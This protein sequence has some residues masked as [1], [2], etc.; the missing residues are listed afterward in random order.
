MKIYDESKFLSKIYQLNDNSKIN[1]LLNKYYK[2]DSG[3][4]VVWIVKNENFKPLNKTSKSIN[5]EKRL[6]MLGVIKSYKNSFI[7]KKMEDGS[8]R[9]VTFSKDFLFKSFGHIAKMIETINSYDPRFLFVWNYNKEIRVKID[10][11]GK[12]KFEFSNFDDFKEKTNEKNDIS[13]LEFWE[14]FISLFPIK[15]NS[16]K[17]INQEIKGFGQKSL[18]KLLQAGLTEENIIQFAKIDKETLLLRK[19]NAYDF[20][21]EIA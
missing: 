10:V 1:M 14:L 16:G 17:L 4:Q 18:E 19:G 12:F 8:I 9:D 5:D 15:D 3:G 21:R 11:W 20:V 7:K 13:K 2:N 6:K